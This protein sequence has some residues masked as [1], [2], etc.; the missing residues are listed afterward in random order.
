VKAMSY[1]L[2]LLLIVFLIPTPLY[3]AALTRQ[4]T[5]EQTAPASTVAPSASALPEHGLEE[6]K[7]GRPGE[8]KKEEK[9]Q[10]G[11]VASETVR[12]PTLQELIIEQTAPTIARQIYTLLMRPSDNFDTA[13]KKTQALAGGILFHLPPIIQKKIA[14][15]LML[16]MPDVLFA[17][18]FFHVETV[19]PKDKIDLYTTVNSEGTL[20]VNNRNGTLDLY[21]FASK[22]SPT[23][24]GKSSGEPVFNQQGTLL[25][26]YF[27]KGSKDVHIHLYDV[28]S[29][30]PVSEIIDPEALGVSELLFNPQGTL[31]AFGFY[32]G[33]VYIYDITDKKLLPIYKDFYNLLIFNPQG[34]LLASGRKNGIVHLYDPINK[35]ALPDTSTHTKNITALAFSPQGTHLVSGSED[36]AIHFYDVMQKRLFLNVQGDAEITRLV[37]LKNLFASGDSHGT[38][39]LYEDIRQQGLIASQHSQKVIALTSNPQGTLLA[40][41][42]Q[43]GSLHLYDLIAQQLILTVAGHETYAKPSLKFNS[44]GTRLASVSY[45]NPLL[46]IE[47]KRD[48]SLEQLIFLLG[49]RNAQYQARYIKDSVA[50]KRYTKQLKASPILTTFDDVDKQKILTALSLSSQEESTKEYRGPRHRQKQEKAHA[51]ERKK[52]E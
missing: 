23:K 49:V 25:A 30:Q 2:S 24:I 37:V 35:R 12:V 32:P 34:T 50:F 9:A 1:P 19:L 47:T 40:S 38:V 33:K 28:I 43:D 26:Y 18:G 10:D 42:S 22:Q 51:Q 16:L 29:K 11:K 36:G 13:Y 48:L 45:P 27:S 14:E 7:A 52:Q 31:L 21:D 8:H 39:R 46:F 41:Y 17:L 20:L 5:A 4:E 15:Q 3:S 44:Q 6:K